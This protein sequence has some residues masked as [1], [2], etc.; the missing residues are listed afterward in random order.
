MPVIW[1]ELCDP[2]LDAKYP[3]QNMSKQIQDELDRI[4]AETPAAI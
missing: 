3:G 1:E 2:W 4:I